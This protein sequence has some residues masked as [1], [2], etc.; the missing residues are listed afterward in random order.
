MITWL[1]RRLRLCTCPRWLRRIPAGHTTGPQHAWTCP[2]Y[3]PSPVERQS[4]HV[5]SGWCNHG[6]CD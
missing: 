1:R 3:G 4:D 6:S 2:L 5:H